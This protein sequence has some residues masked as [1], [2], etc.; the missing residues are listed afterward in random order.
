MAYDVFGVG[1]SLV[2]IQ[3]QVGDQFLESRRLSSRGG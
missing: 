1:N 3:A 2:D